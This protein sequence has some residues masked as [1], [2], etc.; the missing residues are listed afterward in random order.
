MR[1]AFNDTLSAQGYDV[2]G[3]STVMFDEDDDEARSI[4]LVAAR[5]TDIKM[6]VCQRVTFLFA[7]DLGYTARPAWRWNGPF[8][9]VCAASWFIKP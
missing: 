7:Y 8:M 3:A 9:T 4:Y 6:D 1:D 2:A 5:I